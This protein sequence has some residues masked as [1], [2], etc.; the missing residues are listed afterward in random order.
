M[1]LAITTL[2][3]ELTLAL[4]ALLESSL[5]SLLLV[6]VELT[7]LVGVELVHELGLE[8]ILYSLLLV[9]VDLAVLVG[10]E[11][12]HELS[13]A[14]LHESLAVHLGGGG[15][16]LSDRSG[17]GLRSG[18]LSEN[19]QSCYEGDDDALLHICNFCLC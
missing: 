7:V 10:V 13:L 2:A 16:C 3:V 4:T 1:T 18:F 14:G 11:L 9:L 8:E 6:L 12:S 15:G 19:R 5:Y 17:S